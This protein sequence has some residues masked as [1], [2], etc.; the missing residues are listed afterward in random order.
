MSYAI[1]P[2]AVSLLTVQKSLGSKSAKLSANIRTQHKRRFA[3]DEEELDREEKETSLAEALGHMI[4][5]GKYD[6]RYGHKYGYALEMICE[7]FGE[8]LPNRCWSATGSDFLEA[9]DEALQTAGIDNKAF[10]VY[11]HLCGRGAPLKLPPIG[12]FPDI[13]YVR[14]SELAKA[15]EALAPGKLKTIDDE[16]ARA[17]LAEARGWLDHCARGHLDLVCFYY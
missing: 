3:D 12:D 13:G 15:L 2:I 7:H 14:E 4:D 11:G 6:E 16:E 10:S 17:S 1:H 9:V 5:G 8:R